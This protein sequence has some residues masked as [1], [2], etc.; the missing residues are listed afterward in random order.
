MPIGHH[1]LDLRMR[2]HQS[3]LWWG[4]SNI[5][6]WTWGKCIPIRTAGDPCGL[7]GMFAFCTFHDISGG[8]FQFGCDNE[9]GVNRLSKQHLNIPIWTKHADLIWAIRIVIQKL[10]E[11]SISVTPFHID[12]HQDN[13]ISFADLDHPLQLNILMD[14]T[15]KAKLDQLVSAPFIPTPSDIKFEGWSCWIKDV[16]MMTDVTT[17][18]LWTIHEETMKGYLLDPHHNQMS[19]AAFKLV[20][21]FS[22]QL[23]LLDFS[24]LFQL[25]ALKHVSHYC[26]VGHMQIRWRF[27]DH[28][29]CPCC[30]QEDE[31]TTHLLTCPH[32]G[33]TSTWLSNVTLLHQWLD[34]VDTHPD[35]TL[36]FVQT[37]EMRNPYQL[38][39]AFSTQTCQDAA[40]EQDIIGWQN[41]TEGK[42]SKWW[43]KLQDSHYREG[44][45]QW[46][47][48]RWMQSLIMHLCDTPSLLPLW[49]K[50]IQSLLPSNSTKWCY[51]QEVPTDISLWPF[52]M[53][54]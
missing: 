32:A 53:P 37:L 47:A 14:T 4:L 44:A 12:G 1:I 17:A 35:I 31:T 23:A 28:D 19:F 20:D 18:V 30:Q 25:W 38:F 29:R 52:I 5:G 48:T 42:L 11:W 33:M 36:C 27:W 22:V 8:S 54:H 46:S 39:T 9:I 43:K 13:F 41:F 24:P 3:D 26:S 21:W 16:K 40:A 49:M 6:A 50:T 10:K 15:T 7:I 2:H 45:L 51:Q 34:E